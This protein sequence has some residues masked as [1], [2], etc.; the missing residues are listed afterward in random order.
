MSHQHQHALFVACKAGDVDE[1]DR[2]LQVP[3]VDATAEDNQAMLLAAENGHVAVVDRLLQVPGVDVTAEDN[4]VIQLAAEHGHVAVVDRLLQVP[5]VDA[6]A[7]DNYAIRL[8]AAKGH[9]AVVDRLLQVPGVDPAAQNNEPIFYAASKG[10]VAVVARLLQLPGVDVTAQPDDAVSLAAKQGF[11]E[12]LELLLR[13]A[14]VV[15]KLGLCLQVVDNAP[16]RRAA[17]IALCASNQSFRK[18]LV[19]CYGVMYE[20]VR[21]ELY[22]GF[23]EQVCEWLWPWPV[24]REAV[25]EHRQ[26]AALLLQLREVWN[27]EKPRASKKARISSYNTS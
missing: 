24:V 10:R 27:A 25:H 12:V 22:V 11:V 15:R 21:V 9:L 23:D 19:E 5:G 13:D 20:C 18:E 17:A 2:L 14:R 16:M 26:L 8:A 1:V 3:G 7:D 4:Y 6:T